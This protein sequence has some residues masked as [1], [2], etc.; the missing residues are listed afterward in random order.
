LGKPTNLGREDLKR[1]LLCAAAALLSSGCAIAPY[2][3]PS[4]PGKL[5][6]SDCNR[7]SSTREIALSPRSNVRVSVSEELGRLKVSLKFS[8]W[9]GMADIYLMSAKAQLGSPPVSAPVER[10]GAHGPSAPLYRRANGDQ[11]EDVPIN[12]R[13]LLNVNLAHEGEVGDIDFVFPSFSGP[14]AQLTLPGLQ[15]NRE[16][17]NIEPIMLERKTAIRTLC[18]FK[19]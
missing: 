17:V 6:F 19:G 5:I 18:V 4:G 16:I 2:I 8:A 12:G 9:Q 11:R 15:V 14:S 3:E 1:V 10:V 13:P 7:T